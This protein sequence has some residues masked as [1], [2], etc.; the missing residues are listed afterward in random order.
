VSRENQQVTTVSVLFTNYKHTHCVYVH[1]HGHT[2]E[3]RRKCN[4]V[5]KLSF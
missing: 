3:T 2:G 4:M 5:Q 1:I